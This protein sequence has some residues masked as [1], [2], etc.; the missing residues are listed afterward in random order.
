[1]ENIPVYIREQYVKL[2]YL[3]FS[4]VLLELKDKVVKTEIL[5]NFFCCLFL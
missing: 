3:S 1:M 4:K 2:K 5:N